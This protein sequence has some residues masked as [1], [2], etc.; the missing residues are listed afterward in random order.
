MPHSQNKWS[1]GGDDDDDATDRKT[2]RKSENKRC[3][4]GKEESMSYDTNSNDLTALAAA[5][6]L[7]T[8]KK[9]QKE[10]SY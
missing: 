5:P 10:R 8:E 4:F 9:Q 6:T 1:D 7:S 2:E 3:H